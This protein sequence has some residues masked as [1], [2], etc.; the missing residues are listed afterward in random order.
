[1]RKL[2]YFAYGSNM[3]EP[4]MR[5]ICP[6]AKVVGVARLPGYRLTFP[7]QSDRWRGGVAG[8]EKAPDE[9]VWGVLY[10]I[11]EADVHKL[12]RWEGVPKR[13][14]RRTVKVKLREGNAEVEAFTYFAKP[15]PGGP[16]R[17]TR[18]YLDH[19]VRGAEQHGL[20]AE[21]IE[22]LKKIETSD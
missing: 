14:K 8:L 1:M 7:R 19:I 5:G 22:K 15:E 17:P 4:K 16:F 11:D 20:P 10:E 18:E 12:D 13:Y 3:Y 9:E 2:Y 21:Y 6:S